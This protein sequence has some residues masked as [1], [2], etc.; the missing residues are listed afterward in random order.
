M[1]KRE[2]TGRIWALFGK[3]KMVQRKRVNRQRFC[4]RGLFIFFAVFILAGCGNDREEQEQQKEQADS[5]ELSV[6]DSAPNFTAET[7][8]GK[9][10]ILSEQSGKVVLLN[11]WATWCGP[12]V[13]E[14]PAF[15]KLYK[16][17]GQEISILAVNC[18]EDKEIVNQFVS[19][20]GYRF[21][22]AY[23]ME[24]KIS[25]QYP[26]DGIPYTLVIGK[27]GAVKNMY[28]GALGADE[29]YKE[30]KRAIDAALGTGT[31]QED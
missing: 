10:F 23:D 21:P 18:E 27:D 14:M 11:F 24:G 28:L 6:G 1:V 29:Q 25:E 26:C 17:Y 9:T 4:M 31:K 7:T 15:E 3:G 13:G 16:E 20:N 30:Y 22:I 19:D 5:K 12:C 2:Y 8:D